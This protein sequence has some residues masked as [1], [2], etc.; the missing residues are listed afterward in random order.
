M[1]YTG[2]GNTGDL[3]TANTSGNLPSFQAPIIATFGTWTPSINGSTIPGTFGAFNTNGYY[4]Q[5]GNWISASFAINGFTLVGATGDLIV[6][7]LPF[8]A[9]SLAN[10]WPVASGYLSNTN[11]TFPT[12]YTEVS[13]YIDPIVDPSSLQIVISG[14][15]LANSPVSV[16]YFT[17][18]INAFG[19]INYIIN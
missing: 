2:T 9:L 15:G 12:G 10:Y 1:S 18:G 17:S 6:S 16:L 14:S 8:P 11:S 13:Y 3:E 5:I 4:I 19:T 7:G